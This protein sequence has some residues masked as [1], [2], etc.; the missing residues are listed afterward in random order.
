MADVPLGA[1][2][3]ALNGYGESGDPARCD[4]SFHLALVSQ[5]RGQS[6]N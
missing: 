1:H 5:D 3:L 2:D 6:A 4:A